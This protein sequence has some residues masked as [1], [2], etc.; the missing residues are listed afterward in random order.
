MSNS[1]LLINYLNKS[2]D[3]YCDKNKYYDLKNGVLR[4]KYRKLNCSKKGK[5]SQRVYICNK[6][7]YKSQPLDIQRKII[8]IGENSVMVDSY[9]MNLL[10][11]QMMSK[12]TEK[13][14]S[15]KNNIE[16]PIT[17]TCQSDNN[18]IFIYNK[19]NIGD[20]RD[21]LLDHINDKNFERNIID[22]LIKMLKINDKLYDLIQFQHC[23]MK[24]S[25]I[26]LN[27][28][29][30]GKIEPIISDFDKSTFTL[31]INGKPIRIFLNPV[32]SPTI[33]EERKDEVFIQKG[34]IKKRKKQTKK[35]TKRPTKKL[36]KRSTNWPRKNIKRNLK[37]KSISLIENKGLEIYK[38]F[39]IFPKSSRLIILGKQG[40][41]RYERNP[42]KDNNFYNACLVA[43]VLLLYD[44]NINEFINL[45]KS[46]LGKYKFILK[47]I[48]IKL[49]KK[50]KYKY[51]IDQYQLARNRTAAS[52]V[53]GSGYNTD[54]FFSKISLF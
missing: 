20:L 17:N 22:I 43:S 24:C 38:I 5:S 15:L 35:K 28:N 13:Y 36:N 2:I 14:P 52:C 54:K 21:Y 7:V 33:G 48:N 39:K 1:T 6:Y 47:D 46:N 29:K 45:L 42:L 18:L 31:L 25:A 40:Y 37:R 51:K 11:Q 49:I 50:L 34:G 30:N 12:I 23:D 3:N 9:T 26:L 44:K 10:M 27:R 4:G 16:H 32:D 53:I 41:N 19:T 8:D